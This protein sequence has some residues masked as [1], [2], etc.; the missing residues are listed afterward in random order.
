MNVD[1]VVLWVDSP[2]KSLDF[3]VDVV[4]LAAVRAQEFEAGAAAFPSVRVN[5]STILDLMARGSASAVREFTGGNAD[6][7]HPINHICFAMDA[8]E[9][10]ELTARLI[11]NG[12]KLSSGDEGAFGAQGPAEKSTYFCDPDDNV[13]EIRC[14]SRPR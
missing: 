2:K 3:F 4:G 8:T 1:H 9:F 12:V 5:D 6:A 10:S 7:G 11:A 14:Y 13:I